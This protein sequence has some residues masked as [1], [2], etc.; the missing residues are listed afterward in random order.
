MTRGT[1]AANVKQVLTILCAVVLFNLTITP[2][3]AL[4][5]VFTLIGGTIYTALEVKERS[6]RVGG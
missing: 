3:N 1:L 2:M 5:I 6:Q 4:G